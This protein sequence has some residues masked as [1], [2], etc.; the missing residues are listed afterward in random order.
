[1]EYKNSATKHFAEAL[2]IF[3]E[4]KSVEVEAADE[5]DG[6]DIYCG[7][8]YTFRSIQGDELVCVEMSELFP[9]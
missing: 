9:G 7:T 3:L 2:Y 1:M 8:A 5:Y 4:N 6:A